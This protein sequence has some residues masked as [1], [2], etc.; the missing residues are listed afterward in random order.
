MNE[1]GAKRL[2]SSI[3]RQ[4]YDD[5]TTTQQCPEYCELYD[6]CQN[7]NTDRDH[8]EAKKFLHSAWCAS[9]CDGIGVDHQGFVEKAIDKCR[10]S[11]NTFKYIE[12]ELR[13][14]KQMEK[15]LESISTEVILETPLPQEGHSSTPG[16]P[17]MQK[18]IKINNKIYSN[19]QLRQMQKEVDAIRTVYYQCDDKKRQII[20]L[21]Y[22]KQQLTTEGIAYRLGVD[23]RTISRWKQKIIYDIAIKLG[24]L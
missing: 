2:I 5:Y 8:C 9:L 11:K 18:A 21:C 14:Y 23:R 4:A 19:P 16:N 12:G 6:T 3:L 1:E 7:R 24:Y 22:W 10:L 20:E 15:Q 17:T 13:A